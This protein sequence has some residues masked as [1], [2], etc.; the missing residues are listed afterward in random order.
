MII[1]KVSQR[2]AQTGIYKRCDEVRMDNNLTW[3]QF[4]KRAGLKLKSWMIGIP[5]TNPTDAELQAIAATY[6]VCFDWLKFGTEPKYPA[7][8]EE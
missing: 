2:Q 8:E 4:A 1:N 6:G 5:T 3:S 7:G